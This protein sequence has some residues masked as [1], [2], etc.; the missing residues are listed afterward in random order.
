VSRAAA[1]DLRFEIPAR[2]PQVRH[3]SQP[4]MCRLNVYR[5]LPDVML[6]VRIVDF[7][8]RGDVINA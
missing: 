8:L 3:V 4:E 2:F 1:G 7:V 6:H 5:H